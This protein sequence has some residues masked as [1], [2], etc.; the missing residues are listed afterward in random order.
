MR[1]RNRDEHV[2]RIGHG[3]RRP[4][5]DKYFVPTEA[6]RAAMAEAPEIDYERFR[7]DVDAH[8][9]QDPTPRFWGG[10]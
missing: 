3:A 8:V 9:D 5:D 6:L 7:A 10:V 4:L 2:A 1:T